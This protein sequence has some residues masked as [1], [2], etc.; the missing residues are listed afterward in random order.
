MLRLQ[1]KRCDCGS[2]VYL[3]QRVHRAKTAD[4]LIAFAFLQD[5]HNPRQTELKGN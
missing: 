3:S 2:N 5:S 1:R 4:E